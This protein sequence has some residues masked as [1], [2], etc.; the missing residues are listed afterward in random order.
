M[1][2][3]SLN[4][5]LGP[6]A[7][8]ALTGAAGRAAAA[9]ARS[10]G[11]A[12]GAGGGAA[13]PGATA[14]STGFGCDSTTGRAFDGA[15]A[16]GTG[17]RCSAALGVR[18]LALA[19]ATTRAATLTG[20]GAALLL[21]AAA[22]AVLDVAFGLAL[23]FSAAV[24]AAFA[25]TARFVA[26]FRADLAED[27]DC[28]TLL[29]VDFGFVAARAALRALVAPRRVADA[30]AAILPLLSFAVDFA[31]VVALEVITLVV[32]T[33]LAL[34]FRFEATAARAGLRAEAVRLGDFFAVELRAEA[35]FVAPLLTARLASVLERAA[36]PLA[37]AAAVEAVARVFFSAF[38]LGGIRGLLL[39]C[40]AVETGR[41]PPDES[42]CRRRKAVTPLRR[43]VETLLVPHT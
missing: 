20:F 16:M 15:V 1:N 4:P 36:E 5:G 26:F 24:L 17:F 19:L 3:L 10:T 2:S 41:S 33:V 38:L 40:P 30:L 23:T 34:V 9:R 28:G 37:R 31:F 27:L 35:V 8:F 32:L 7:G 14:F 43:L 22:L 13:G 6:A 11:A 18:V 42:R 21:G 29:G 39:C 12:G 25:A